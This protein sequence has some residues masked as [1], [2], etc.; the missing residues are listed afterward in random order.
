[1]TA[2]RRLAAARVAAARSRPAAGAAGCG[3]RPARARRRRRRARDPDAVA[4]TPRLRRRVDNPWLPLDAGHR[5]DLRR[6]PAAPGSARRSRCST[7]P[8]AGRRGRRPPRCDDESRRATAR[9]SR[10]SRPTGT[11]RTGDGNVW[12]FGERRRRGRRGPWRAG[13]RRRRGRARDA[14]RRRGSATA[15]STAYRARRG[16]GPVRRCSSLDEHAS[17]CRTAT[18]DGRPARHRGHHARSSR[19]LVER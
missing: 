11:P 1:M 15:T 19:T 13:G 9:S 16:R 5:V 3:R 4:R 17:R 10:T 2:R 8:R 14:G 7:D 18:F 12:C 6:R